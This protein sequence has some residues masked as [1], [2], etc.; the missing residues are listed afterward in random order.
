L[1]ILKSEI[2]LSTVFGPLNPTI[3]PNL[4]A[5]SLLDIEASIFGIVAL[6]NVRNVTFSG[7]TLS[8]IVFDITQSSP[9]SNLE[10]LDI[11][12]CHVYRDMKNEFEG[13]SDVLGKIL[14]GSKRKLRTLK[15]RDCLY[16]YVLDTNYRENRNITLDS[17]TEMQESEDEGALTEDFVSLETTKLITSH[18]LFSNFSYQNDRLKEVFLDSRMSSYM[19]VSFFSNFKALETIQLEIHLLNDVQLFDIEN[20]GNLGLFK[21][22]KIPNLKIYPILHVSYKEHNEPIQ[23]LKMFFKELSTSGIQIESLDVKFVFTAFTDYNTNGYDNEYNDDNYRN[24]AQTRRE[25]CEMSWN[26]MGSLLQN[27]NVQFI[28][29]FRVDERANFSFQ[30]GLE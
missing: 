18:A 21:L 1:K 30:C 9:L 10:Y 28:N 16:N 2:A 4:E 11:E 20:I 13:D 14:A 5:I 12:M 24:D 19:P 29:G 7:W 22:K 25:R 6:P 15:L 26:T 23:Q 27:E 8:H 17:D 3:F